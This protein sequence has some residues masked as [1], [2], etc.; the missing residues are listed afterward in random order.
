MLAFGFLT[1]FWGN[2]GQSFF[3]SWFGVSIQQGL[4]LTAAAYGSAYS[5]ATLASG[6][7]IMLVGGL[8]DRTPL[9]LFAT[10]V[11]LGLMSAAMTLANV[12]TVAGLTIGFFLLRLFGQGLLPHTATTT[13]ARYFAVNRGKAISIATS[14][15]PVG[16]MLLP[17]L[18]VALIAAI[19]WQNSWWVI[20]AG[21]PLLY[22]PLVWWLL[23]RA[24]YGQVRSESGY[25][26]GDATSRSDG[27]GRRQLLADRRF[28]LALPGLMLGPFVLTGVFIHQGWFLAQKS[29]SPGWFASC[30]VAYGVIHW[31]SSLVSGLLV[32]RLGSPHMLRL[33]CLPMTL[34]L[35]LAGWLGGDWA[36]M[37][38]LILFGITIGFS[39]PI[40]GSLWAEIYGVERLGSIRSLITS[41]MVLASSTSPVLLGFLID[42]GWN[43]TR[44]FWAMGIYGVVAVGLIFRSYRPEEPAPASELELEER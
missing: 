9:R 36:A 8:L 23:H 14:G 35:W 15:V 19:G 1:V 41:L 2:F 16:E 44:M 3:V 33:Y 21:V 10:L 11:A 40:T 43:A 26:P 32:D 25:H 30:F 22:L 24:R 38:M 29:W 20:A 27:G 12:Q 13:M 5:L 28:W 39:G 31:L 6:M 34:G 37:S 17:G 7:T 18:A 4:G 42:S